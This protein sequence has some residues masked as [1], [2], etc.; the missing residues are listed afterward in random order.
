M[1]K[2]YDAYLVG[3]YGMKNS[4]D[5]ALMYATAWATKNLLECKNTK[6]GLYGDYS[7]EIHSDNKVDL[8]SS[9]SFPGQNRLL[10]YG[11][12]IQSKRIIFGGGSVLHS[13][14][15]INLKRQLMSLANKKSSMAVGVGLGPFN[16]VKA[17]KS[18]TKFLNECG[19]V[20]VRD[21]ASFE[22]GKSLSPHANLHKTFDLA[23]LLLFSNQYK[24]QINKRKGIA[25]TL[26]PV[27][28][29]AMGEINILKEEKRAKQFAELITN[30]Y[31]RT[32]EPIS[33]IEFNGHSLLGDW[34]IYARIRKYLDKTIPVLLKKYEPNPIILLNH[35]S[36]YKAILS[37][38]L[39]GSILG[40]LSKTPVISVN[41]HSKCDGWCKE[42]G[43]P[44]DYQID[45]HNLNIDN[46]TSLI[47]EGILTGFKQPRLSVHNALNQSLSNWSMQHEKYK[48][49]SS[50]SAI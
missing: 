14:R 37:M 33:L 43:I 13:E 40:F 21:Q 19:Y 28:I 18:C 31:E 38:R 50:Y 39:H 48:F 5:D 36:S 34:Q 3:Y 32:D 27:A 29:N 35:L 15:D 8:S 24:P 10:H 22:L 45:L 41:Y 4:G 7:R 30:I 1:F 16:S 12:A 26:C 42:I 6:V 23:P 11:T 46:I 9:Q 2:K 20:G 25:L 47:H 44:E 17:E 49:Y